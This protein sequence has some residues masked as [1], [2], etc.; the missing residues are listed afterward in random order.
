MLP[1]RSAAPISSRLVSGLRAVRHRLHQ[2][3]AVRRSPG[4]RE[5]GAS[6]VEFAL[7]VPLLIPILVAV[8]QF[9]MAFSYKN[10]LTQLAGEGARMAAVDKNPGSG[11]LQAYIKGQAS[12]ELKN[13][14]SSAV[15]NP[16]QV[17]IDSP[18]SG[19]VRVN[20]SVTYD[21]FPILSKLSSSLTTT[22]IHG[23]ATMR[24]EKDP[25]SNYSE[26][27]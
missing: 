23:S 27:C 4:G 3:D 18:A 22:T 20:T 16:A 5:G 26:G 11:T 12:E 2:A 21:W 19:A 10:Q 13:G 9:G 17:C 15:P 14:G 8:M 7:V 24:M 6:M 1:I 25:P